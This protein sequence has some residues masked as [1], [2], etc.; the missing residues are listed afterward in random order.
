[1]AN[2]VLLNE[3]APNTFF[4]AN[5]D[6][7]IPKTNAS[8]LRYGWPANKLNIIHWTFDFAT[9]GPF[10]QAIDRSCYEENIPLSVELNAFIALY[11]KL[12]F[13]NVILVDFIET[14]MSAICVL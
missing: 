5:N 7:L 8:H 12:R 3:H 9:I 4:D 6:L 1:M 2:I 11:P 14:Q 10:T 13:G